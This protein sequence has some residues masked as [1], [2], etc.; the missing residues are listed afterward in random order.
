M[1]LYF[2][3]LKE[4]L[5]V[6]EEH[7]QDDRSMLPDPVLQQQTGRR[8]SLTTTERRY[9][10]P[11]SGT[12]FIEAAI[13]YARTNGILGSL[14]ST[15]DV[16][17]SADSRDSHDL[18]NLLGLG[19]LRQDPDRG[20]VAR[21]FDVF[22]EIQWQ[23][24]ALTRSEFEIHQDRFFGADREAHPESAC[25][26]YT[27]VAIS[28]YFIGRNDGSVAASHLANLHYEKA[29]ALLPKVLQGKDI[30]S[31]QIIVLLLLYSMANPQKPV[32]WHLLGYAIRLSTSLSLH[33]ADGLPMEEA[34][35]SAMELSRR[36][37]WSLYCID[38][39]VCNTLGR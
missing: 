17:I 23:Y 2:E 27:V 3:K 15:E 24:M 11:S 4:R 20:T 30:Y 12:V 25:I 29:L 34:S 9:V 1:E 18:T 13:T 14:D 7:N 6:L 32:V 31:L 39:G 38:R 19:N 8:P 5:H 35:K 26:I 21:L 10:G 33:K 22:L 28:T 16:A 37:F 36:V